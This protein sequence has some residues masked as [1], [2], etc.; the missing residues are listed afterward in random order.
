MPISEKNSPTGTSQA[1]S[2]HPVAGGRHGHGPGVLSVVRS[3]D[4]TPMMRRVT[5]GG[6]D[7]ARYHEGPNIKLLV[8]PG[9]S[10][11]WEWPD[12]APASGPGQPGPV[13][14]TFSVRRFDAAAGELDIDFL[15]H[16]E[17]P[18]ARWA[19]RAVAGDV[20]GVLGVGGVSPQPADWYLI[21]G[22]HCALP[23]VAKLLPELPADA[24]GE[25]FVSVPGD[26]E[27]QELL[28]PAGVRVHWL[29][30]EEAD[31]RN[32]MADAVRGADWPDHDRVFAWVAGESAQVREVR[33]WL[34]REHG[35]SHR[36]HLAIGY[37]KRG[38]AEDIYHDRSDN[39]RDEDYYRISAESRGR[40]AR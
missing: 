1:G 26:T 31:G 4:V 39:D 35:L 13:K 9:N 7:L 30:P 8:P 29:P 38:L 27:R 40:A 11:H 21:V 2:P 33:S 32:G 36:Q 5:L 10:P 3:S 23:A 28:A 6:P 18:A 16:G 15:L 20:L 12:S 34:R 25:V 37:W 14:R 24:R 17:G 19:E 22:D